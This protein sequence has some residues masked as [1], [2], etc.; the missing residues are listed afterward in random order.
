MEKQI[1][2]CIDTG[3]EYCPCYLSETGSCLTCSR[4]Q[5][6]D[7][8]DC[9][10]TGVCIYNE[11]I[12]N[13]GKKAAPRKEMKCRIISKTAVLEDYIIFE[14]GVDKGFVIKCLRPG[15]YVFMR[16]AQT[17]HFYDVPLSLLAADYDRGSISVGVR[18]I[19]AKTI[20]LADSREFVMVRGPYRNGIIGLDPKM[21]GSKILITARGA[22]TASAV[23]GYNLLRENNHIDL[24]LSNGILEKKLLPKYISEDAERGS[25]N[26]LIR[27]IQAAEERDKISL[28]I[29][30]A[31]YDNIIVL[32]S[33][34]FIEDFRKITEESGADADKN[35]N[36][37]AEENNSEET[38][39]KSEEPMSAAGRI[40]FSNNNVSCC[41]EGICGACAHIN[42]DGRRIPACKCASRKLLG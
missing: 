35:I 12:L 17:E 24:L 6:K 14:V 25:G 21:R 34:E 10:W 18:I 7:V 8:C 4:L 28:M 32:G 27:D 39:L 2:K 19:S 38:E 26:I 13:G 41:G 16:N 36:I 22:G 23:Y 33:N 1:M 20:S 15:S 29:K 31:G 11:F 3:S 37:S 30:N 40:A 5:G 9:D 42:K